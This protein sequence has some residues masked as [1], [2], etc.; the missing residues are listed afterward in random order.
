MTVQP[1]LY[2]K[3]TLKSKYALPYLY[4]FFVL[5]CKLIVFLLSRWVQLTT[6][7]EGTGLNRVEVEVEDRNGAEEP[8]VYY[9]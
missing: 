1:F 4:N 7:D 6:R 3:E 2:M 8:G 9:R 5:N